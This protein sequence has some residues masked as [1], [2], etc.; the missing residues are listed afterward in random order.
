MSRIGRMPVVLPSGV[1]VEIETGQVTVKGSK[2]ELTQSIHPDMK[3]EINEGVLTVSRPSDSK[4]HRSLHGLTR[5]LI[6]NMVTGVSEGFMKELQVHGV[7]YRAQRQDDGLLLNV[8]FSHTVKMPDPSG[9]TTEV[10][11]RRDRVSLIFVRGIDR[12]KVGQ[13]AANI[14]KV[15]PPEPYKGKGIRYADEVI[16]L[17]V[18]KTGK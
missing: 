12:Q 5:K 7:G 18:G 14:R 3:V 4:E 2:G 8:G 17:K 16:R 9:I 11:E 13:H 15:R 6:S 10:Q 1:D